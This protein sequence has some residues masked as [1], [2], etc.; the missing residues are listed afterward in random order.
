M[1]I[2]LES[3]GCGLDSR[4]SIVYPM[5]NKNHIDLECGVYL[6]ECSEEWWGRLSEEDE[7]QVKIAQIIHL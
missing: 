5:E 3:V 7:L 6:D 1:I 2:Y 4:E